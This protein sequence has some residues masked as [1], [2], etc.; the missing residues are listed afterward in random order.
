MTT[1]SPRAQ[2]DSLDEAA[3]AWFVRMR[4]DAVS[5]AD[6][7]CF[8]AW[9]AEDSAHRR[10][11]ADAEALWREMGEIPDPRAAPPDRTAAAT[12]T[13]SA[14]ATPGGGILRYAALTACLVVAVCT[15]A[16]FGGAADRLWA[17][18]RTAIGEIARFSL[19]D[20]STVT[21]NTGSAVSVDFDA[22]RRRLHLL[23][24]EAFFEV[25][26]DSAR[27]FDVV[28][29]GGVAR[30]VGTAFNVRKQDAIVTVA[31]TEGRVRVSQQDRA[32]TGSP[33][34]LDAGDAIRLD[35]TGLRR[36]PGFDV[37]SLTA[38]RDGKLVFVDR[39]LRMLIEEID[40]YRP[41]LIL[42]LGSGIADQPFSGAVAINDTDSALDAIEATLPVDV[43]RVGGFL[44]LLRARD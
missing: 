31:V 35:E 25:S 36:L 8:R 43:I 34:T 28:A 32:P 42:F 9:L 41:G 16:W 44:T 13:P 21:L 29:A 18:H 37:A 7:E 1:Q 30:A 33:L 19:P 39:P 5:E 40:R 11:Y 6:R 14:A 10:A 12:G 26:P 20:G 17:D 15:V 24:G 2:E 4:S 38:W 27:P 3:T 23:K 22:T